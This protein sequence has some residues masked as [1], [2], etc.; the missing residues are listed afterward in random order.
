VSARAYSARKCVSVVLKA[1]KTPCS[2]AKRGCFRCADIM[3]LPRGARTAEGSADMK[4]AT[5]ILR[6]KH[7]A[8]GGF[9]LWKVFQLRM[10]PHTPSRMICTS[11]CPAQH[12][13]HSGCLSLNTP[14]EQTFEL[15][16]RQASGHPKIANKSCTRC[17]ATTTDT[18]HE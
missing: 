2:T 11:A 10:S 14:N 7:Y 18:L 1:E 12:H 17:T 6:T 13:F 4:C 3:Q 5:G 15:A 8:L 16:S 9:M